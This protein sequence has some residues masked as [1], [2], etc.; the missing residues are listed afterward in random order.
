MN[1]D[2][3]ICLNEEDD[4]S[5]IE[6]ERRCCILKK[7]KIK[8][9]LRIELRLPESEPDVITNYTME[10]FLN[11]GGVLPINNQY[12]FV[13]IFLLLKICFRCA[14]ADIIYHLL[15]NNRQ[16]TTIHRQ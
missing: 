4:D 2:D 15:I 1:D 16:P 8:A 12:I 3:S 13:S 6:D 9:P 7:T 11:F 14:I 10:P 5:K